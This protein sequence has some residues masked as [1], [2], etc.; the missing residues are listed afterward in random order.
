VTAD[1]FAFV[2]EA[3]W[4]VEEGPG[5]WFA[6]RGRDLLVLEGDR[7]PR[8]ASLQALGLSAVRVQRLG[9]L[10]GEACFSAE[11]AADAVPPAGGAFRPVRELLAV[12]EPELGRAASRAVQIVE[13]DRTHQFCGACGTTTAH[14]PRTRARVCGN[15]ACKLSQY[16]RLSPAVIVAVERGPEILL[17]RSPHFPSGL[18]SVLAGFVDPG[19]SAEDAVHR[20]VFE[21]VGVRVTNLRYFGSQCWPFP[22][23]MM[24][25]F[26]ADYAGGTLTPDPEEIEAAG[27]YRADALPSIRPGLISIS[28]WLIQDFRARH[29]AAGR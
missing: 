6:F 12:L 2:P 21:E 8:V 28:Q 17:A 22:H 25:A 5:L 19:E 1:P 16:P 3:A 26:Q 29:G 13:W 27:F 23:S 20:E 4:P 10:R 15:P 18:F 9:R 14:D 7:V 24:L 11:L